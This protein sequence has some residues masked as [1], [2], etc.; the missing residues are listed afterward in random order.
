MNLI[1]L[2]IA[3]FGAGLLGSMGMGG[4]G[5]LVIFLTL[6]TDI[7]QKTA[8][9]INLV[10]FIPIAILS[11]IIYQR[12]KLINWRIALPFG[13]IG[14]VFSLLGTYIVGI[15]DSELL[16]KGFG[17][18]LIIMG[19]REVFAKTKNDETKTGNGD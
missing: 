13:F 9:G 15:T 19:I 5:I 16:R 14:V 10:F 7:S 18:L 8:Q 3:S 1:W 2:F 11:I 12:R 17:V 4:G 6:C